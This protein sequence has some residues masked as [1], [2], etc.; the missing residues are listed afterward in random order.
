MSLARLRLLVSIRRAQNPVFA[1]TPER[2]AAA[3]ARHPDVA[4]RIDPVFVT[5]EDG[6]DAALRDADAILGW[7]FARDNLAARAPRLRWIQ[8]TGA[9]A[10][11]LMPLDWLP[12]GAAITT[13]SGVHG[14]KAREFATMA[15]LMLHTRIP[16]MATNQQAHRWRQ[17]FTPIIAGRTVL[18]VGVGAMG[19]AVVRAARGLGLQV[20]GIRRSGRAMA[21]VHAMGTPDD[22]DR[23]LPQADLVA[24]TAPATAA[25]TRLLGAQRLA[26][27]K[28]GAG[29]LNMGRAALVDNA[30]LIDALEVGAA[31][32]SRGGRLRPRAPARR[33]AP[34]GRAQSVRRAALLVRRRR[35]LRRRRAGPDAGQRCAALGRT[36][37]QEPAA[38]KPAVLSPVTT[39]GRRA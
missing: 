34:V 8:L 7:R 12:R 14:A 23:F 25:T 15:L 30:A 2:F 10:E 1:M 37:A 22:L 32:R 38:A 29:L 36:G 35:H 5:D 26:L 31:V 3:C 16:A 21:G 39:R 19:R 13:A 18:V 27:I 20:L 6:L 11:H 17:I 33:V 28:P 9:G 24:L 4:A